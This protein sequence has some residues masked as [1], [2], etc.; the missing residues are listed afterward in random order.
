MKKNTYKSEAVSF[1]IRYADIMAGAKLVRDQIRQNLSFAKRLAKQAERLY[2]YGDKK[3]YF[4]DKKTG[5]HP[6]EGIKDLGVK[7]DFLDGL[8]SAYIDLDNVAEQFDLEVK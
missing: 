3:C 2:N 4:E 6:I 8:S 5:I 7:M 1:N